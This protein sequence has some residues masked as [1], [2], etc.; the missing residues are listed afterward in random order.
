MLCQWFMGSTATI[1]SAKEAIEIEKTLAAYL[2][3]SLPAI[4]NYAERK[5]E[6]PMLI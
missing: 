3:R 2:R 6:I 5:R 4:V 1:Q